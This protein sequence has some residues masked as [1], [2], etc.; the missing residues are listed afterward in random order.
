MMTIAERELHEVRKSFAEARGVI[1]VEA[2]PETLEFK[3]DGQYD[4]NKRS[5][6]KTVVHN[7]Q[8]YVHVA[9][10]DDL[11]EMDGDVFTRNFSKRDVMTHNDCVVVDAT[12]SFIKAVIGTVKDRLFPDPYDQPLYSA[13]CY[14]VR[15]PEGG[16]RWETNYVALPSENPYS[17]P[18]YEI[19]API[20]LPLRATNNM[21][22]SVG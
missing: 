6:R 16:V 7:R 18:K 11:R 17:S 14:H 12:P 8:L 19:Y 21:S 20:G 15:L 10:S 13:Q 1:F 22:R 9:T 2:N 5:N 3:R 4:W